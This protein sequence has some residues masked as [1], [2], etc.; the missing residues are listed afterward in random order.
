LPEY[1]FMEAKP[2]SLGQSE[3]IDGAKLMQASESHS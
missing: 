3:R 1:P 2:S